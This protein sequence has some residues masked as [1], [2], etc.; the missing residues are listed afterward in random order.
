MIPNFVSMESDKD[1]KVKLELPGCKKEKII[2]ELKDDYLHIKCQK[3]NM[4]EDEYQELAYNCDGKY[5]AVFNLP[6][7][8]TDQ[9]ITSTYVD[10]ILIIT[11][12]KHVPVVH[13]IKVE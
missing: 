7:D 12:A 6:K 10:G 13:T 9:D 3:E 8:T 4:L 5:D 11:I 1:Y 2:I